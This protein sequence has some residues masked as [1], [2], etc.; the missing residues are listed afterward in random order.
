[1]ASIITVDGHSALLLDADGPLIGDS[2][3]CQDLVADLWGHE[4][5]TGVV[6]RERFDPG[7]FDLRTGMAGDLHQKLVNY[8]LRL[9]VLGDISDLVTNSRSLRDYVRESNR[10]GDVRFM[11]A[12]AP[13]TDLAAPPV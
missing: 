11:D 12:L 1:M 6:P 10:H 5:T 13:S 3:S 8:R 2:A 7:F 4:V 9:I